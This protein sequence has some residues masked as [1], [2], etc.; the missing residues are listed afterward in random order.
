M[1]LSQ[2][3][4]HIVEDGKLIRKGEVSF[5]AF[6]NREKEEYAKNRSGKGSE[7]KRKIRKTE[8]EMTE[9]ENL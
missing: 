3:I 6:K 5:F 1:N 7:F 4:A 2:D 9:K 8:T